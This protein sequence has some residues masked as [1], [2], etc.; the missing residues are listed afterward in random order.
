MSDEDN[1]FF[2]CDQCVVY[3]KRIKELENILKLSHPKEE[4]EFDDTIILDLSDA[5]IEYLVEK[6]YNE[7]LFFMGQKGVVNFITQYVVRDD[8]N[9]IAYKCS[10]QSKKMF[11]FFTEK[12]IQKDHRCKLLFES[13]YDPLIKKVN[14]IYRI[15]LNRIYEEKKEI[16][17]SDSDSDGDSYD[18]DIEEVIANELLE[19]NDNTVDDKVNNAVNKFLEIKKC[20]GKVKKPIIDEL[21]Q[22]LYV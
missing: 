5:H 10:D 22:L 6:Y 13:I 20:I 11:C 15:V 2:N 21:T 9:K 4:E 3:K 17:P 19:N 7:E 16:V 12:G 18:S 8:D 1:D 14:K